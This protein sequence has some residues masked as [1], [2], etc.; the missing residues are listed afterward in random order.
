MSP[1]TASVR[2]STSYRPAPDTDPC[3][4]VLGDG[5]ERPSHD[6]SH[7]HD[8]ARRA[9]ADT[10]AGTSQFALVERDAAA[11][12]AALSRQAPR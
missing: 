2:T 8:R 5:G 6:H 3:A 4:G 11:D 10:A 1:F 7:R 9:I 12:L